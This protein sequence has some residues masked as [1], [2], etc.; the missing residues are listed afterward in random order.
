MKL[1]K[2]LA[3]CV[4]EQAP[5]R[6]RGAAGLGRLYPTV[7]TKAI[8]NFHALPRPG[9]KLGVAA[10]Q[11]TWRIEHLLPRWGVVKH[12]KTRP[13]AAQAALNRVG[14]AVPAGRIEQDHSPEAVPNPPHA[15]PRLTV[16]IGPEFKVAAEFLGPILVH[17]DH[18]IQPPFEAGPLIELH[19]SVKFQEISR[20]HDADASA[21]ERGV[22]NQPL[23][24]GQFRQLIDELLVRK[25]SENVGNL[26]S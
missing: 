10:W 26:G 17:A 6:K 11:R 5:Q 25:S 21:V 24:A 23:D 2:G 20:P 12:L 14:D 1:P 22:G 7:L 18:E 3:G 9:S 19:V 15:L 4:I 16:V 8:Q 13:P